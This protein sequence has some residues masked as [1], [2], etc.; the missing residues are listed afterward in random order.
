M[1]VHITHPNTAFKIN[2]LLC[3]YDKLKFRGNIVA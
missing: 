2:L 3:V 1:Q